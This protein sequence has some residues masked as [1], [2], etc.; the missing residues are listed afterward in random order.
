ME[1]ISLEILLDCCIL[2]IY[3]PGGVM[4]TEGTDGLKQGVELIPLNLPP[5]DLYKQ[6]FAPAPSCHA[7][8]LWVQSKL[9][10]SILTN[11]LA[12]VTDS[13][14]LESL[15]RT[16]RRLVWFASPQLA[17]QA[18]STALINWQENPSTHKHVFGVPCLLQRSFGQ[19]N[20]HII[21][22]G[23]FKHFQKGYFLGL[24]PL[25]IFHLPTFHRILPP[26]DGMD[27]ASPIHRP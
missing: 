2:C 4:I 12:M 10:P 9:K 18:M 22:L 16:N 26:V 24:T 25:C 21:Y 17:R 1:I 23:A 14:N 11:P 7:C 6:L 19:V 3:V 15:V 8:Q 13:D 5:T 20:K 27:K